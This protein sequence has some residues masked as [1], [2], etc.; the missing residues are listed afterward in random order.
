M[1]A[2]ADKRERLL[3]I[4]YKHISKSCIVFALPIV[5]THAHNASLPGNIDSVQ[6]YN[7]Q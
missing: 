6:S 7:Y 3:N 1:I 4:L 2:K 5:H